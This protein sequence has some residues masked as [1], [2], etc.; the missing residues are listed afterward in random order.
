MQC[1][2]CGG[3]INTAGFCTVCGQYQLVKESDLVYRIPKRSNSMDN[4]GKFLAC[5]DKKLEELDKEITRLQIQKD[6]LTSLRINADTY[7][8][9]GDEEECPNW[10]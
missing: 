5:I 10:P 2:F 8:T 4:F 9:L 7:R 6:Q 1:S 3:E